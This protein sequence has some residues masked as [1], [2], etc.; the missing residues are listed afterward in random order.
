MSPAQLTSMRLPGERGIFR[1]HGFDVFKWDP[2]GDWVKLED[3]LGALTRTVEILT[4][5][6]GFLLRTH[7]KDTESKWSFSG[8]ERSAGEDAMIAEY[9]GIADYGKSIAIGRTNHCPNVVKLADC[10]R[11]VKQ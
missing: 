10:P 5:L 3:N 1:T 6:E 2:A 9:V 4:A 8:V 7:Q 11:G